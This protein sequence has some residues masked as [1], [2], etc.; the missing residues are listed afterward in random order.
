[1]G[2]HAPVSNRKPNSKGVFVTR[3]KAGKK[4]F[5]DI[6][7]QAL[8]SRGSWEVADTGDKGVRDKKK[9]RKRRT[10]AKEP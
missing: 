9:T 10:A 7:R 4:K 3:K 5:K 1:V 8:R 2:D 6:S